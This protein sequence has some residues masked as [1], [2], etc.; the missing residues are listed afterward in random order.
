ME[1]QW[2]YISS[3]AVSFM[4]S[5]MLM[6]VWLPFAPKRG[7]DVLLQ[8]PLGLT[9]RILIQRNKAI[10]LLA[11]CILGSIPIKGTPLFLEGTQTVGLLGLLLVL[12]VPVKYVFWERGVS[13]NNGPPKPYKSYRRFDVRPARRLFADTVS[14]ILRGRRTERGATSSHTL[15]VPKRNQDDVVRL[16]KKHVR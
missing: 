5:F 14:V 15:F 11:L 2:R 6:S 16:L 12:F 10:V 7:G 1:P 4:L 9:Q 3:T 8:V 13:V